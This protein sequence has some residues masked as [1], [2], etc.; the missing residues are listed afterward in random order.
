M[1][2]NAVEVL[3]FGASKLRE[4]Q[5]DSGYEIY[6]QS[7]ELFGELLTAHMFAV[8]TIATVMSRKE[9][10][11]VKV[12]G[13]LQQQTAFISSFIQGIN[14]VDSSI[15]EGH[16]NQAAALIRQELETIV[17]LE[18]LNQ[19]KAVASEAEKTV[20]VPQSLVKLFGD[21][22]NID[23]MA[24]QNMVKIVLASDP[25]ELQNGTSGLVMKQKF[26]EQRSWSLF[27]FHVSLLIVLAVQIN[28]YYVA[29]HGEG[30]DEIELQAL[31]NA[32]K[33]LLSCGWLTQNV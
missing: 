25:T 19:G 15:S 21:L 17:A 8:G 6:E 26:N 32:Q 9:I 31:V 12:G 10:L 16:Y 3:L 11:G 29:M 7:R 5:V 18:D 23:E 13:D 28:E 30:L 24:V 20:R 1:D 2:E 22:S 14:I 4:L 27:G 33:I